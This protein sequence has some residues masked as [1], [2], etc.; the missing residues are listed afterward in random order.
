MLFKG[1]QLC[2]P[3]GSMRE[4]MMKEKHSGGLARYFEIDKIVKLILERYFWPQIYK[5]V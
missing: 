5:D 1:V 3:R 2:I 4:N